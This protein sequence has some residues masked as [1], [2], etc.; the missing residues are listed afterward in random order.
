MEGAVEVVVVTFV[1][2]EVAVEEVEEV[3]SIDLLNK[4]HQKKYT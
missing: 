1:A 4:D 2:V 3:D